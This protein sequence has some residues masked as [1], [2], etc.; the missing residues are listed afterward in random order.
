MTK[1]PSRGATA[2][3]NVTLVAAHEPTGSLKYSRSLAELRYDLLERSRRSRQR[4]A[5]HGNCDSV[6]PSGLADPNLS[7]SF[8]TPW[9]KRDQLGAPVTRIFAKLD[10]A[11]SRKDIGEPLHA[12][13]RDAEQ[14]GHAGDRHRPCSGG[15]QHLPTSA[16]LPEWFRQSVALVC[17][18]A[19]KTNDSDREDRKCVALR[20]SLRPLID[21]M[22]SIF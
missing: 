13:A 1:G 16:S 22:L 2:S 3:E 8:F 7:Q 4:V 10:L 21:N 19:G 14:A 11:F 15:R 20:R 5:F 6:G 18:V 17:E 12:L 9:R